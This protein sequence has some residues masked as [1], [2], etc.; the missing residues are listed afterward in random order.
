M[1]MCACV[2]VCMFL[3]VYKQIFLNIGDR[4]YLGRSLNTVDTVTFESVNSLFNRPNY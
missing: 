1:G 2:R 4:P 3:C